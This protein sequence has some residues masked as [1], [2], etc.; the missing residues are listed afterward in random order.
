MCVILV[1][2]WYVHILVV[3]VQI[4]ELEDRE[5]RYYWISSLELQLTRS[6]L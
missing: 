3:K 1:R 6:G 4:S 2:Y 5:S